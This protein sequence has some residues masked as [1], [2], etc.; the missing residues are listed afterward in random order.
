MKLNRRLF[1]KR[2]ALAAGTL[3]A[4]RLLPGPNLLAASVA[5]GKLNCVQIGCGGRSMEHLKHVVADAKENLV[6]IVEPD[7][8]RQATIRGWLKGKVQDPEKLQVF[9]DYRVMFDK[10]GKG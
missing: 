9:T 3:S 1:L 10:V 7:E 4:T 2:A 8:K 5:G 6:A